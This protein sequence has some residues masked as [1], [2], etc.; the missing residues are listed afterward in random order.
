MTVYS[1]CLLKVEK[2]EDIEEI[3]K[4]LMDEVKQLKE[5]VTNVSDKIKSLQP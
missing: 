3:F 2:K 1:V 4:N 5:R